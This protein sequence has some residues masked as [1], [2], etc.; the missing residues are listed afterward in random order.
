[1]NVNRVYLISSSQ[2]MDHPF[3]SGV[4]TSQKDHW[5]HDG[6]NVCLN[7]C[8]NILLCLISINVLGEIGSRYEISTKEG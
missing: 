1:M 7:I 2:I 3:F 5:S 4:K 8:I 6:V